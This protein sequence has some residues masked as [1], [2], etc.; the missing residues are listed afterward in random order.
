MR[1]TRVPW[2]TI[3]SDICPAWICRSAS[4]TTPGRAEKQVTRRL[5]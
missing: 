4:D 2:A 3:S 1:S 5:I